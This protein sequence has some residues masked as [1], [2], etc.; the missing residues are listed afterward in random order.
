MLV[1]RY[2]LHSPHEGVQEIAEQ[3][4]LARL[5]RRDLT[6]IERGRRAAVREVESALGNLPEKMRQVSVCLE[7]EIAAYRAVAQHRAATRGRAV[8]ADLAT[9][10][11]DARAA[12]KTAKLDARE[13]RESIK[14]SPAA[15]AARD[16]IG[17]LAKGLANNAYEHSG[18]YWGTRA[19]VQEAAAA[20]F[21]KT[22]L[23]DSSTWEPSDPRYGGGS[24]SVGLQIMGGLSVGELHGCE[25]MRLRLRKPDARAWSGARSERRKYG[26]TAELSLRIG[27]DA[28]RKPIWGKWV[29]DM[30]R[31]LPLGATVLYAAVQR[32][33]VA[34]HS[35][36]YVTLTIR[37]LLGCRETESKEGPDRGS[38][39]VGPRE[40]RS[41][42]QRSIALD[43]GWRQMGDELRVARWRDSAGQSGELRLDTAL[44]RALHEPEQIQ[45]DRKL[46]FELA[47]MSLSRTISALRQCPQWL[48]ERASTL[49]Q[50]HS[51]ARLAAL[52]LDWPTTEEMQTPVLR[53]AY[54]DL[55]TWY[56]RDRHDWEVET[57]QRL[58]ALRRRTEHYRIFSAWLTRTYD[59]I[60]I[61][62]FD[63]R[64]VAVRPKALESGDKTQNETA[65]GNRTIAALSDLRTAI[66][67][68]A[69]ARMAT[70]VAMPSQ[71][72][73]RK[74]PRCQSVT[75]RR[76]ADSVTI[77]CACG[78]VWDQ[79]DGAAEN[80]LR[81]WSEHPG[82]AEYLAG[83]RYEEKRAEQRQKMGSRWERVRR[84]RQEK[85]A[86]MEGARE[87]EAKGA[88]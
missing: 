82:D 15:T 61:E 70:L 71:D 9:A 33:R 23:Y 49:S 73:T 28:E 8:P 46:R 35:E 32:K 43:I 7:L 30:Y 77:S 29:V 87:A 22:P 21:A 85:L 19:L 55:C 48:S 67:Q 62:K 47:K 72:T 44:L 83:A 57:R 4:H 10:L 56:Y 80:L 59:T 11:L 34:L 88:E 53:V 26:S 31:P 37:P 41:A 16:R 81:L 86:R 38:A 60:V 64:D 65:R 75:D 76:A 12:T 84:K 69:R 3:L 36:W 14:R 58:R 20:S 18:L 68:A 40:L 74:C 66:T 45:G 25:D 5:Y 78:H 52:C 24:N 54:R 13:L 63:L 51:P 1:Y 27:T 50:W 39:A 42:S 17:E 6:Q 2:R 79:D